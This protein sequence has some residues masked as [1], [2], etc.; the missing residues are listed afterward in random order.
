M[1]TMELERIKVGNLK[2]QNVKDEYVERLKDS[3]GKIK[4]YECLELDELWKGVL[5]PYE[6]R[7]FGRISV[8][9]KNREAQQD[10]KAIEA[11]ERA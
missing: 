7:S 1:V 4:T 2:D 5:D 6:A 10:T 11:I 8:Y 9:R 3:L